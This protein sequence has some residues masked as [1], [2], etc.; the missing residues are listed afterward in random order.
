MTHPHRDYTT[1]Q[2]LELARQCKYGPLTKENDP[3]PTVDEAIEII[4]NDPTM[5]A[6]NWIT[7]Q[8][9]IEVLRLSKGEKVETFV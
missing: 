1:E 5:R 6:C 7:G 9:A 8:V 2:A 3:T 4:R